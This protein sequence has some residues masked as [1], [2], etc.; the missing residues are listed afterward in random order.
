MTIIAH[1]NRFAAEPPPLSTKEAARFL[2]TSHR[3][4]EDW[5]LTGIGPTFIK[6]GRLVRYRMSDIL[7]YLDQNSFGSTGGAQAA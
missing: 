2:G 4:M 5:R 1:D 7:K 6:L 3:T